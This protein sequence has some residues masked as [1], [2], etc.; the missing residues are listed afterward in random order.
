MSN[1]YEGAKM[2]LPGQT[3]A[4]G[5]ET[6]SEEVE[7]NKNDVSKAHED[8]QSKSSGGEIRT[9]RENIAR[10][11]PDSALRR[12]MMLKAEAKKHRLDEKFGKKEYTGGDP[13]ILNNKK[14]IDEKDKRL[15][16]LTNKE[17]SSIINAPGR[18]QSLMEL[19]TG[20]TVPPLEGVVGEPDYPD[21]PV[22]HKVPNTDMWYGYD[23]ENV[24]YTQQS[25]SLDI[26]F[27]EK[28]K[29]KNPFNK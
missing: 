14:L 10:A 9:L 13:K 17:I 20:R 18:K 6:D 5:S 25:P 21:K 27:S 28:Q 15:E 2:S 24:A 16:G 12:K 29:I 8:S 4:D 3:S 22:T 1:S 11:L 26:S 7:Q 23:N 19:K